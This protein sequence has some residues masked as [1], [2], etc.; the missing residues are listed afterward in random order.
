MK[1]EPASTSL[2]QELANNPEIL[3]PDRPIAFNRAFVRLGIG[4]TGALFLSQAL[5]WSK[6]TKDPEGWFYK[7]IEDWQEETGLTKEEQL[8]IKKKLT[9]LGFLE[10]KKKGVPATNH[11]KIDQYSL[12]LCMVKLDF[13]DDQSTG[14]PTTG[15]S[16]SQPP[17][18]GNPDDLPITESTTE[19]TSEGETSSPLL[20]IPGI[21]R[22]SEYQPDG[23]SPRDVQAAKPRRERTP[24]Q[25]AVLPILLLMDYFRDEAKRLHNLSYLHRESLRNAKIRKQIDSA[26]ATFQEETRLFVDWWLNGG[27]AWANYEPE[28]CFMN[29]S[30]SAYENRD[31]IAQQPTKAKGRE[32]REI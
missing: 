3:L 15:S 6:R 32:V 23:I 14:I 24:K 10:V 12:V 18:D 13:Y 21:I 11:F 25:K 9:A 30:Y 26:Y 17:V 8:T 2:I 7:T 1:T 27:G 20:K 16:D 22:G 28:Q 29:K 4:V 5:Y 19:S 31:V